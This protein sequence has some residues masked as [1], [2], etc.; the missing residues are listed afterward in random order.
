MAKLVI[1]SGSPSPASRLNGVLQS[2]ESVLQQE[3]LGPEWI[4]VHE[5]PPEDLVYTRFESLAISAANRLIEQADGLVVATPIYKAAYTGVLKAFLDL[6]PQ[7]GLEG[8]VIMPV[9][10]G[11]SAAHVWNQG[12]VA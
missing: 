6:I 7:R 2:I 5:L 11:S 10:I 4:R 1:I 3:G 8:K 12:A 9:A